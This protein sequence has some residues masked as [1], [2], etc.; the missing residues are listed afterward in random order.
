MSHDHKANFFK[1]HIDTLII[2]GTLC[3]SLIWMNGRF[4][5]INSKFAEI[6]KDMAVIKTVLLV[7][8]PFLKGEA[9]S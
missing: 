3:S 9:C 2:M 4:N 8:N 1:K 7:N 5:D 6:K